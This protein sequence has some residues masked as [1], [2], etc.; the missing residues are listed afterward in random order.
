[1]ESTSLEYE[2]KPQAIT[3]Q[4]GFSMVEP[5]LV[6]IFIGIALAGVYRLSV[7]ELQ[8][9][10]INSV[11]RDLAAWLEQVRAASQSVANGGCVV[12]FETGTD[13]KLGDPVAIAKPNTLAPS[14]AHCGPNATFSLMS[15]NPPISSFTVI[16]DSGPNPIFFTPRG[17]VAF[18]DDPLVIR[19]S[20]NKSTYSRCVQVNAVI[21]NI[22][23]GSNNI[24]AGRC[25][26]ISYVQQF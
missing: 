11:S 17:T 16:K 13:K 9:E 12:R 21:G 14:S 3:A 8:R 15:T 23:T 25:S 19:I 24:D 4:A 18:S 2:V 5:L 1:M 7:V 6:T 20:L 22:S 10:T 26:E